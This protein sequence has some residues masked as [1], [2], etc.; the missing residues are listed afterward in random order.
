MPAFIHYPEKIKPQLNH[1]L[2]SVKDIAPTLLDI[3]GVSRPSATFRGRPVVPITG[4]SL[5]PFLLADPIQSERPEQ[6]KDRVLGYELFGK[7]SI[8]QGRWSLVHMFE[9]YGNDQWQLYDLSVDLSESKDLSGAHPGKLA[10][11][12]ALWQQYV[13]D[14]NVVL[15]NWNSGY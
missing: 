15:P 3:T 8:R 14:N 1:A 6:S 7:R 9:P 5:E 11:M 4:L 13:D 2:L 12:L 10:E